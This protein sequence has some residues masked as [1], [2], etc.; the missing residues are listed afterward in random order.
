MARFVIVACNRTYQK[1]IIRGSRY[2][3][4]LT[5]LGAHF[6]VEII[7]RRR[8]GEDES[9]LMSVRPGGSD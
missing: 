9:N 3:M 8:K 1:Q 6:Y 7:E 5:N 2:Q 4:V